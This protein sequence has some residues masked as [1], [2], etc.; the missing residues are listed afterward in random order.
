LE[1]FNYPYISQSVQ[2]FWR[3]WH[4]SLS[5]WFRDYV[6][7]PLGGN[8]ISTR[9]TYLN[10]WIIFLLCGLWH[11]A[12]WNFIIWGMLHGAYLVVERRGGGVMLKKVGRPFRHG[13]TLFLISVAWVFFR[14]ETLPSALAYFKAM[15]GFSN[16]TGTTYYALLYCDLKIVLT[17]VAGCICATPIS[18]RIATRIEEYWRQT[19]SYVARGIIAG[20]Y[21][22]LLMGLFF[23]SAS[24]LAAGTYNPFIYFRF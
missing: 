14:A 8:R 22:A 13:Y 11:G 15:F 7:I 3:R 2:E 20:A 21:Y 5:S 18:S 1:N 24:Y 4:L 17:L 12:S 10:L 16:A 23:L 9:R 6:Y 19:P